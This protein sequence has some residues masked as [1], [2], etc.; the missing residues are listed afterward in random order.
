MNHVLKLISK[1]N[2]FR[3][4]HVNIPGSDK[5]SYLCLGLEAAL[6]GLGRRR[7]TGASVAA[8]EK[9][10]LVEERLVARLH[11]LSPDAQ[12][13]S[14]LR[15]V[16][17]T[18]LDAG[19]SSALGTHL[20]PDSAP[21]HT[22]AHYLFLALLDFYPDLAY[23]VGLRAMRLSILE[24][25]QCGSGNG[26]SG[27]ECG[28]AGLG[29]AEAQQAA[30]ASALLA[31]ARG[32]PARL[33]AVLEAARRHV[34]SPAQLF[35]LAQDALRHAAPDAGPRHPPLLN[36]AFELG[37]QVIFICN[38]HF[39]ILKYMYLYSMNFL[40]YANDSVLVKLA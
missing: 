37:L 10:L 38:M 34:R 39:T 26:N 7:A 15:R 30:L 35:R 23:R 12:L 6:L 3:Y 19:P 14:V 29:A 17:Q 25:D 36:V 21:A 5:E 33:A 32:E 1:F 24:E 4:Q 22:F 28:W 20:P 11:A 27:G 16:A 9:A 13:A 40:G 18:L 2:L 8:Q 31:A